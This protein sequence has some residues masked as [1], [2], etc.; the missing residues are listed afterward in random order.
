MCVAICRRD[1]FLYEEFGSCQ[2]HF[3]NILVS[4]RTTFC[5]EET[6]Q[7]IWGEPNLELTRNTYEDSGWAARYSL[8]VLGRCFR[9]CGFQF[10]VRTISYTKQSAFA[11][12]TLLLS[13]FRNAQLLVRWEQDRVQLNLGLAWN[14][15]VYTRLCSVEVLLC[16]RTTLS[17]MIRPTRRV[18]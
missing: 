14:T 4:P 8:C 12:G 16:S 6:K 9:R 10:V 15:D 5:V 1:M 11:W 3:T 7:E 18:V 17:L 2:G 13:S